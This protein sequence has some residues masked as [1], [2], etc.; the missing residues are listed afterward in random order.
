MN[1]FLKY[2]PV[3]LLIFWTSDSVSGKCLEQHQ[4][5][6]CRRHWDPICGSDGITYSNSCTLNCVRSSCDRALQ[7][8]HGGSC[9]GSQE[10]DYQYIDKLEFIDEDEDAA[11]LSESEEEDEDE[12]RK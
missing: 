9:E 8:V 3:I 11:S 12:R 6:P 10:F 2:L 4:C 5:G 1:P 7:I